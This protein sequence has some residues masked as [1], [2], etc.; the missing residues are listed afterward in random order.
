MEWLRVTFEQVGFRP[1][2]LPLALLL[3]LVS[4]VA[5]AGCSL[6]VLGAIVGFSGA[7][8]SND[9]RANWISALCFMLG[10]MLSLVVLG[11]VAGFVGQVT[12]SALG[13][14]WKLI[15]GLA[16]IMFG[17]SVL[18]LLP[19]KTAV[20]TSR[21]EA[22]ARGLLGSALF[23]LLLGGGLSACS[24]LC[25]G[26]WVFVM[27]GVAVLQGHAA[28]GVAILTAYAVGFSV[29]LAAI[30]LGVSFGTSTAM[31]KKAERAIRIVAGVLLTAAGFYF[32]A[33]F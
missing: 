4:A 8:N 1:L 14:Y 27:L 25:C 17:L 23:G 6:P 5:S 11:L 26:P 31:A 16:A 7:G 15:A 19:F 30:M 20:K 21:P 2:A 10:T 24:S 3:G 9:R 22:E 32:L 12:Q 13:R 29:P 28:W 18:K 33:T